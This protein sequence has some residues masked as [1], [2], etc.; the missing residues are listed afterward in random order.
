MIREYAA[1]VVDG[2]RPVWALLMEARCAV[3]ARARLDGNELVCPPALGLSADGRVMV[4]AKVRPALATPVSRLHRH[5]AHMLAANQ[6]AREGRA[7]VEMPE[8]DVDGCG[9]VAGRAGLCTTHR[10]IRNTRARKANA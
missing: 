10:V 3:E 6:A 9:R 1:A 2:S 7:L 5:R 8:C 4:R